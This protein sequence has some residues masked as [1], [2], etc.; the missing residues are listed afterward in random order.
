MI[1]RTLAAFYKST[2]IP[3]VRWSF[4]GAVFPLNPDN[5]FASVTFHPEIA[6]ERIFLPEI[7]LQE[8]VQQ[9]H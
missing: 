5:L 3:I 7:S 6:I 1:H 9:R 4:A 8:Y 2:R